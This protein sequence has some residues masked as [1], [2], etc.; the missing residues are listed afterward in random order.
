M[1][2]LRLVRLQGKEG[3]FPERLSI[4]TEYGLYGV[5]HVAIQ[6]FTTSE[7]TMLVLEGLRNHNNLSA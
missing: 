7:R 3:I 4:D 6:D 1:A 2:R 5:K